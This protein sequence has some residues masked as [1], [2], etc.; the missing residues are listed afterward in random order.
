MI[1]NCVL[2]PLANTY[3]VEI[4]EFARKMHNLTDTYEDSLKEA[5][6]QL[7]KKG[8]EQMVQHIIS[9][10]TAEPNETN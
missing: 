3:R 6:E 9:Q 1:Y 10:S 4:Q 7:A 5:S 2:L 8:T